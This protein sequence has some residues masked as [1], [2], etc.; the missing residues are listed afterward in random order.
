MTFDIQDSFASIGK[1]LAAGP[2]ILQENKQKNVT[3]LNLIVIGS[4]RA[5]YI[6]PLAN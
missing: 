3:H 6:I 5:D 4:I 1:C 2:L